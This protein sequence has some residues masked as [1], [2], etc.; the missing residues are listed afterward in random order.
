MDRES[1]LLEEYKLATQDLTHAD[2]L[3]W[4]KTYFFIIVTG[5][6]FSYSTSKFVSEALFLRI[7]FAILG[8]FIS[9]TW[10]FV[11]RRTGEYM[12]AREKRALAIEEEL[13]ELRL[14]RTLKEHDAQVAGKIRRVLRE[15]PLVTTILPLVFILLWVA[16]LLYVMI[17]Q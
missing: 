16:M 11:A 12:T 13:K 2:M 10:L 17:C 9:I 3:L 4:Q 8:L 6:L 15:R 14:H 7:I 5:L 1:L